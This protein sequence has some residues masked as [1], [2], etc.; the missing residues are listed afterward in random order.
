M[1]ADSRM[2]LEAS[3]LL[4]KAADRI[5]R[6]GWLNDDGW[7]ATGPEWFLRPMAMRPAWGQAHLYLAFDFN[8]HFR[9]D[10]NHT[11]PP[12]VHEAEQHLAAF[13]VDRG[14][15]AQHDRDGFLDC[16]AVIENFEASD[17]MTADEV[18]ETFR[19]CAKAIRAKHT[20]PVQKD[21]AA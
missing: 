2:A 16:D 1:T 18:A 7:Y 9:L 12:V 8:P 19:D 14:E 17:S 20:T 5:D 6:Y 4:D 15:E 11:P 10:P 13:L 21:V 3:A